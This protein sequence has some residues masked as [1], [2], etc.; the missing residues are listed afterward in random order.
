MVRD[1]Y[2]SNIKAY[3]ML[4]AKAMAFCISIGGGEIWCMDTLKCTVSRKGSVDWVAP[5]SE[6]TWE[7]QLYTV[8]RIQR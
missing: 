4:M 6:V 8:R 1:N 5:P 7:L 3:P 2:H